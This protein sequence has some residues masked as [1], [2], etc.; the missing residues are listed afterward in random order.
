MLS[1]SLDEAPAVLASQMEA[2][3]ETEKQRRKLATDLAVYQGKE[4]YEAT[5]PDAAGMRR[6]V[7][8]QPTG[9][10]DDLRPVAQSFTAQ[11]KAVFIGIDRRSAVRSWWP[12]PRTQASTPANS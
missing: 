9:G 7:R 12:C 8:R 6:L 4:L 11:P 5:A 1:S 3:R 10:F 2:A